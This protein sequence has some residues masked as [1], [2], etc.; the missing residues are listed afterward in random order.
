ME[1][2]TTKKCTVD[3]RE[4]K[5]FH[6]VLTEGKRHQIRRMC[7]KFGYE[8]KDLNRVRIMNIKLGDLAESQFREIKGDERKKLFQSIGFAE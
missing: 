8:V 6:I 4:D 1:D 5:V 3:Q 7:T 2:F